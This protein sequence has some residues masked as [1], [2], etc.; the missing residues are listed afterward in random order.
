MNDVV[1]ISKNNLLEITAVIITDIIGRV[2]K[3]VKNNVE[4]INVVDLNAGVYFLKV[5]TAEG[6]GTTKLIKN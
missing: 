6:F 3:Q 1:N 2:V 5:A 4:S